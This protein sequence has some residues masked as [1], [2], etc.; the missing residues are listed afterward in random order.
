M[1]GNVWEWVADCYADSYLGAPSDGSTSVAIPGCQRVMRGGSWIDSPR[2]LR[3][4][5]RG[6]VPPDS[7]FIYR[8]FRVA[9]DP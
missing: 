5:S 1:H 7:R 2:V 8:G 9:R 3:S 4:A 6:R